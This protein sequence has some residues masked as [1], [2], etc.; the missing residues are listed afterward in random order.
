[1][2]YFINSVENKEEFTNLLSERVN[3]VK[4]FHVNK[5]WEYCNVMVK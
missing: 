3:D 5:I 1:M 2:Y 4:V